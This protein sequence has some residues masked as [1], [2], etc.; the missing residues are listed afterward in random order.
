MDHQPADPYQLR[1]K[2]LG[3]E[4]LYA[5][6]DNP[7]ECPIIIGKDGIICFISRYSDR[8]LGI[9]SEE[10]VGKHITE[11]VDATHLHEV[12]GDGKARIGDTLYIAGRQQL[13][14]RIPIKDR[15]GTLLGAVG[16][17]MLN[18]VKRLWD[19]QRKVELLDGQLE[20]YQKQVNRLKGGDLIIGRS[21]P[22]QEVKDKALLAAKT[23][24]TILING[25]SGSGK[26][27]IAYFIHTSSPR[28]NQPFIKVNCAS[29]PPDL[30][31][32][33]L[34]GYEPGAFTG[35]RAKGKPGKFEMAHGGTI[36]LD[37]IGELPLPMQAKLLRVLQEK[38]VDRL[39]GTTT[40]PVDFRLIAAT[41]RDLGEMI[42]NEKFRID[43]FF[44]INVFSIKAPSLREIQDDIPLIANHLLAK[45]KTEITWGPSKISKEAMEILKNGLWPG[46]VRE[47]RNVME[48]ASIIAKTDTILPKDLPEQIRTP[49]YRVTDN[50]NLPLQGNLRQILEEV[51]KR[52]IA[53]VLDSVGGNK[54]AAA[55]ILGIHRT[56]LYDKLGK[57]EKR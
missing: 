43:L 36:L 41:N 46:N 52:V 48:K 5:L 50:D 16:K 40:I 2:E 32:S 25:E 57:I 1:L 20:Y 55:E 19:L 15:Q 24:S 28:A 26:E 11:V 44:R 6:I 56:S 22:I 39:G 54:S 8:L 7:Y 4:F 17:G 49:A 18:E 3:E 33:E 14:S 30:F 9:D 35:A 45:L 23:S 51:E 13:I 38:T 34:F 53:N 10:A 31:E 37:E 21:K 42:K 12:L 29:I 47:L 27:V